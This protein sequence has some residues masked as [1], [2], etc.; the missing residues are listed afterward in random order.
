M[1]RFRDLL[2]ADLTATPTEDQLRASAGL[3]AAVAGS[4]LRWWQR[5]DGPAG[6][7]TRL[8]LAVA[9][10]SQY[11]LTLLDLIDEQLGAAPLPVTVYVANLLEYATLAELS[12]DFPGVGPAP[13]TPIVALW[14]GSSSP[15]VVWGKRG[16]D[17]LARALGLGADLMTRW[18]ITGLPHAAA[19]AAP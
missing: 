1:T 2:Q 18:T 11:D 19:P 7:G 15:T 6:T 14:D 10:Y 4:H 16:R 12:A 13:Q 5:C 17:L 3:A 9:P 8:L